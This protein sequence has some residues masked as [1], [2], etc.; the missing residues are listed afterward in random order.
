MLSF[1]LSLPL[2]NCACGVNADR[3]VCCALPQRR[4]EFQSAPMNAS[5]L[6]R[7]LLKFPKPVVRIEFD[8]DLDPRANGFDAV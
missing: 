2:A 5:L 7:F 3:K 6:R 1:D 8:A 4:I